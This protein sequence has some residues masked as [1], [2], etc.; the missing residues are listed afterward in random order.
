MILNFRKKNYNYSDFR[1]YRILKSGTSFRG[2][3]GGKKGNKRKEMTKCC[4]VGK[5]GREKTW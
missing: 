3:Q 2:K 5:M 4:L 1:V